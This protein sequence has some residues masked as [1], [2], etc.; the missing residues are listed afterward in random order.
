MQTTLGMIQQS[1]YSNLHA[2][3]LKTDSVT[4]SDLDQL[5]VSQPYGIIVSEQLKEHISLVHDFWSKLVQSPLPIVALADVNS[6]VDSVVSDQT[7]GAAMLTDWL[8][9]NGRRR[10]LCL[11]PPADDLPW[12]SERYA[13][14]EA[15][16]TRHGLA[17]RLAMLPDGDSS[18]P[19]TE[20]E[21]DV[22]A[23]RHLGFIADHLVGPDEVDAIMVPSDGSVSAVSRACRI[24]GKVPN[25][26][27]WIAGYDNYWQE[28]NERLWE[29][30]KPIAT[31]DKH[32]QKI[33]RE[34]VSL[35]VDR[36][37][38][39]LPT[40]RQIRKVVPTLVVVERHA[41]S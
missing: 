22:D 10:I 15:S 7:A 13:G 23:R 21:F 26:D 36:V 18:V 29:P 12:V 35:L 25:K 39:R 34:L 41:A 3:L 20:A 9:Q 38:G 27:V 2:V 5:I 24:M 31:V 37:E 16:M 32:N 40:E 33:G 14:Y 6:D 1:H 30:G 4:A 19:G 8:I 11:L 17:P 28:A